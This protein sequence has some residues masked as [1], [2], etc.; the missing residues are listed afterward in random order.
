M[1]VK[2][3]W[4]IKLL[5]VLTALSS[6]AWADC[7]PLPASEAYLSRGALNT[8]ERS[9][10]IEYPESPIVIALHGLGDRKEGFAKLAKALPTRWRIIFVDAPLT[11]HNGYAWYRFRCPESARDID[12]STDA[13]LKLVRGLRVRYPQAPIALFGFSQGGVMT[14]ST[15]SRAPTLFSATASLSGYWGSDALPATLSPPPNN[16]ASLLVTHGSSD[17]VVPSSA[18][19]RSAALMRGQGFKVKELYFRGGHRITR[20]VLRAMV[21]HFDQALNAHVLKRSNSAVKRSPKGSRSF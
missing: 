4:I 15:M 2:T 7:L 11:Y 1:K 19:K 16:M 17:R 13:L 5:I 21:D 20:S 18:G 8:Q 6:R 9:P 14:L 3:A 12:Q 10:N